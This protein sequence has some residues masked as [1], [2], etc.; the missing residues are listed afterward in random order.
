MHGFN[1]FLLLFLNDLVKFYTHSFV[2]GVLN[3][4]FSMSKLLRIYDSSLPVN[5][6]PA[7]VMIYLDA[8]HEFDMAKSSVFL[9]IALP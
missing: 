9:F 1:L 6:T 7:S 2:N 3:I 8:L 5:F 4:F